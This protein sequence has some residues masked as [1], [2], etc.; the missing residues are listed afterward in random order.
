M[1]T[2]PW[3]CATAV[4]PK[5]I[6]LIRELA[7]ANPSWGAPR[8]HGEL[9]K[10]GIAVAQA[11]VSRYLPRRA[12]RA[13][14]GQSWKTFLA[15]HV[16]VSMDIFVVPTAT[17]RVLYGLVILDHARR[18][19]RH[20]AVTQFPNAAWIAQQLRTAFPADEPVPKRILRDRDGA[21]GEQ[22]TRMLA[23]MGIEEVVSAPAARRSP[24][25]AHDHTIKLATPRERLLDIHHL[26]DDHSGMVGRGSTLSGTSQKSIA[27]GWPQHGLHSRRRL[28]RSWTGGGSCRG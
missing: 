8:I 2:S 14:R 15:N 19:V 25:W 27:L 6:A 22:V 17:F 9:R 13:P 24:H 10:L 11:T 23:S 12:P 3:K 4:D 28:T 16:P 1:S 18:V 26:M 21:Y 5:T 20:C 7:A